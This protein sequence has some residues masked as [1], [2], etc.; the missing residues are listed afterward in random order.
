[1]NPL[2]LPVLDLAAALA[3]A[4]TWLA[5]AFLA[6]LRKPRAGLLLMKTALL[7]T[8]ARIVSV[9]AL[10]SSGWWFVQETV[11]LTLPLFGVSAAAAAF[12][13]PWLLRAARQQ[14]AREAAHLPPAATVLLFTTGYAAL[15]DPALTLVGGV[16]LSWGTALVTLALVATATGITVRV[17][18]GPGGTTREGNESTVA[19]ARTR[20]WFI[21]AA[22]T[23]VTAGVSGVALSFATRSDVDLGGGP[24]GAHLPTDGTPV[25]G[26]R[27][28]DTPAP[29]GT[30]RTRT[31]TAGQ[32]TMTLPSGASVDTWSYDDRVGGALI[33][34]EE[35]DLIEVTLHNDDI[36]DG[37]TIHWHGYDLPCGEDGAPGVT[38]DAVLPGE[39][40]TYRFLADQIG[41]YWFHTHQVSHV[42]VRM[43][44]YGTLIV[45]AR[46]EEAGEADEDG[47]DLPLP[48]HTFE[49]S[50]V[51]GTGEPDTVHTVT[52]GS[53]VRLRLIN[54]DDV[55]RWFS[56]VGT[57][58]R[59]LAVDGRELKET[60]PVE[61]H[62][63]RLAAGGR[64][65]VGFRAP[66]GSAAVLLVDHDPA[67]AIRIVPG[68]GNEAD[69][70]DLLTT[71]DWPELDLLDHGS[72]E[73]PPFD[74]DGPHDREFALVL[75]RNIALVH[76]TPSYAQTVNARG[77]PN[78][79]TQLVEEGDLVV[80]T[81]VNRSFETHPWHLHGHT[82]YVLSR[83]G[84]V[85]SDGPIALDTFD[86]RPG[87]VWRVALEANNPGLWMN[88]CHNLAHAADGMMLRLDYTGINTPFE[89][90]GAH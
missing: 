3:M 64:F 6:V 36:G 56:V 59:L 48:V 41:T 34:A 11:L 22:G 83:D 12:T 81:V 28:P 73:S 53:P 8:G 9:L 25:T 44:L 72:A 57:G 13:F 87:E 37:V 7:A 5:T 58:F 80:L 38:Q 88:H 43:G 29:G 42:G 40:F 23:A 55:P 46:E 19:A 71:S 47:L 32:G 74:P 60:D 18:D 79:P 82:A 45:T 31:F 67:T 21:G 85:P 15:A 1:M 78:I 54:T 27:G 26:L 35:G 69:P 2:L 76:G 75:D 66:E 63:L 68:N 65:D 17:M 62:G 90:T 16:P 52:P 4:A 86:V 10:A 14:R 50:L 33:E 70:D 84:R 61:R 20:R 77:E 51:V 49:G 30:T 24:D 89:H 39:E